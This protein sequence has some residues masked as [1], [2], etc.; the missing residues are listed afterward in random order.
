MASFA[1]SA[2]KCGGRKYAWT[3]NI[4]SYT[5]GEFKLV[6]EHE[7]NDQVNKSYAI[8]KTYG[9]IIVLPLTSF[10]H[11]PSRIFIE[12]NVFLLFPHLVKICEIWRYSE[13][14]RQNT[15]LLKM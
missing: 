2:S 12:L 10:V 5:F 7:I 13:N 1:S 15:S 14:Y 3:N 8:F 6:T 4:F 11:S 9:L